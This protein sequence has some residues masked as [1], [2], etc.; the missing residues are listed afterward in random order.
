MD[1]CFSWLPALFLP[2]PSSPPATN[3]CAAVAAAV[4]AAVNRIPLAAI[5]V[6]WSVRWLD[7]IYCSSHPILTR[8]HTHKQALGEWT[9]VL[10]LFFCLHNEFF[11][12]AADQQLILCGCVSLWVFFSVYVWV[13]ICFHFNNLI[14]FLALNWFTLCMQILYT[15]TQRD[16]VSEIHRERERE[17]EGGV[18]VRVRR[19]INAF[20]VCWFGMQI[21]LRL[22][23]ATIVLHDKFACHLSAAYANDRLPLHSLLTSLPAFLC[24]R[25]IIQNASR[26]LSFKWR[27]KLSGVCEPAG[28]LWNL[29]AKQ[30]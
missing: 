16:W 8:T 24:M 12:P 22:L 7:F 14:D 20:A 18:A 17:W 26:Q 11:G 10:E 28:N 9:A 29:F 30:Q 13:C 1:E 15:H 23:A 21:C 2:S 6:F 4:A 27:P 19:S 3:A 5:I 25:V